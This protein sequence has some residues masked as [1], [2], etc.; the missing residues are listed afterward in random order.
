MGYRIEVERRAK[1]ALRRL[2]VRDMERIIEAIDALSDTPRPPGC[3]AVQ[4][5][6]GGTY[7]IRVGAYRIIYVVI[8]REAVILIARITRRSEQTY[9]NL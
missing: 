6:P 8:D 5:A 1:K 7:R 2:P 3:L 9:K 4:N